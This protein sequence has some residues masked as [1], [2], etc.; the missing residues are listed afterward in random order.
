MTTYKNYSNGVNTLAENYGII[1]AL[2]NPSIPQLLV[3]SLLATY[4][5]YKFSVA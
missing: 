4:F 3:A 2:S 1:D 5:V